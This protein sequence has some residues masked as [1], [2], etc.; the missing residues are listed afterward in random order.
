[1]DNDKLNEALL[2]MV[3]KARDYVAKTDKYNDGN[4]FENK[5]MNE[6]EEAIAMAKK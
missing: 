4:Y 2:T 5:F 6:L 1:M 3:I